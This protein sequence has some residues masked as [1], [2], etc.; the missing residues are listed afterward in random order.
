[1]FFANR[2]N[3][4]SDDFPDIKLPKTIEKTQIRLVTPEVGSEKQ[5]ENNLNIYI[6]LIGWV[7]KYR[8]EFIF[9]LFSNG[10]KHQYDYHINYNYNNKRNIFE[11]E[12]IELK[13]PPFRK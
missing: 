6:N 3:G 13:E 5:K 2:K 8:A 11:L 10:L 12:T 4:Q 1:L 7:N 9:I